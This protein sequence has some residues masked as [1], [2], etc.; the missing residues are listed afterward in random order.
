MA[1]RGVASRFRHALTAVGDHRMARTKYNWL[2]NTDPISR[3]ER[4][5]F[6][7]LRGSGLKVARAW[8][9]KEMAM[10]LWGYQSRAWAE[11]AWRRWYGRAIRSRLN[12]II[13][14]R[15]ISLNARLQWIKQRIKPLACGF[16][17]R[18]RFRTAVNFHLGA[19]TNS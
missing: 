6:A 1:L 9:I 19:P 13:H 14:A 5:R 18:D 8:A 10:F 4:E 7:E 15:T 16:R 3:R 11:K 17:S 2:R 12:P